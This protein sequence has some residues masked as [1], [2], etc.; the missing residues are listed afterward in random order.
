MNKIFFLTDKAWFAM[1][2][3]SSFF[4]LFNSCEKKENILG[5]E[6][7]SGGERL[8]ILYDTL[9]PIAYT[10]RED[11]LITNNTSLS[12]LGAYNDPEFG[13][14]KA[15]FYTQLRIE[16]SDVSFDFDTYIHP[17]YYQAPRIDSVIFSLVYAGNYKNQ[18]SNFKKNIT[19]NVYELLEDIYFDSTYY[20]SQSFNY[21]T[22]LLATKKFV[23]QPND[24]VLID[25]LLSAPQLRIKMN[26][27]FGQRILDQ[28]GKQPLSNDDAFIDYFKGLYVT[29]TNTEEEMLY[30]NLLSSNSN[31]TIYYNDTLTFTLK[32]NESCARINSF[33]H[34]YISTPVLQEVNGYTKPIEGSEVIYTQ[35]MEGFLGVFDF[36]SLNQLINDSTNYLI[37][38]A[39]LITPLKHNSNLLFSEPEKLALVQLD[40]LGNKQFVIDQFEGDDFFGGN[41]YESTMEYRFNISRFVSSVLNNKAVNNKLA[42]FPSGSAVKSDRAI[43]TGGIGNNSYSK[44][45]L[46]IKYSKITN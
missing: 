28:S 30:F 12:I 16:S 15:S 29:T 42:V 3:F 35:S 2:F 23:A 26:N 32:I 44:S 4:L 18:L 17:H 33:E 11:S 39:E 9:Y 45:R 10:I 7:Q 13:F 1:L 20:A 19:V 8:E 22:S 37:N 36:Y 46:I 21:S 41:Y 25:T 38:K 27:N 34:N 31:V 43:L 24:S 40:S 6:I 5:L 14:N